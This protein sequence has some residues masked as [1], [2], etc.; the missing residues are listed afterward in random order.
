MKSRLQQDIARLL[1][2][3]VRVAALDCINQLVSLLN[4]IAFYAFGGLR[5]VP[6]AAVGGAQ[7]LN[8]LLQICEI[9]TLFFKEIS[10]L[11]AYRAR[12]VVMLLPVNLVYFNLFN[13]LPAQKTT[14]GFLAENV[15]KL[16]F[17][18]SGDIFAVDI[19]DGGGAAAL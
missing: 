2:H 11:H 15:G 14:I 13:A 3:S 16:F 4:H 12:A 18:H 10:F 1:F 6:R 8:H 7:K 5:P 17:Y 9:V 19:V